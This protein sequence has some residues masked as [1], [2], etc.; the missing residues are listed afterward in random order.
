MI[1]YNDKDYLLI[2]LPVVQSV[3][4]IKVYILER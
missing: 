2:H 4:S 3:Y 1:I